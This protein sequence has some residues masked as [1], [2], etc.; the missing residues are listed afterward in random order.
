MQATQKAIVDAVIAVTAVYSEV[1]KMSGSTESDCADGK[2]FL[3]SQYRP[4][5]MPVNAFH[6]VNPVIIAE[7]TYNTAALKKTVNVLNFFFLKKDP[8]E[9]AFQ[10]RCDS[11]AG[12]CLSIGISNFMA[13]FLF[14][15][16]SGRKN[17]MQRFL[18]KVFR[19]SVKDH[20]SVA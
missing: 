16:G 6:T 2:K 11:N 10:R 19:F 20:V 8:E 17:S 15:M 12:L 9:G 14:G 3:I 5:G 1:L 4:R 13:V 18:R 7:T